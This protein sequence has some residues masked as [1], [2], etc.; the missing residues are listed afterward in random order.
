MI[1]IFRTLLNKKS[2]IWRLSSSHARP[3]FTETD[4][5]IIT[6]WVLLFSLL[7]SKCY[8]L[9]TKYKTF[10]IWKQSFK[11]QSFSFPTLQTFIIE[12]HF[13]GGWLALQLPKGG[14]ALEKD[15][16][17]ASY[18]HWLSKGTKEHCFSSLKQKTP[19][20]N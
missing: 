18:T 12:K 17:K 13:C 9:G 19:E 11:F 5:N 6:T 1:L 15:S 7:L 8:D 10:S 14:N 16:S 20:N 2:Q 4:N 3:T